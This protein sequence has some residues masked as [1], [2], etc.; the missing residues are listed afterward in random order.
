MKLFRVIRKRTEIAGYKSIIRE[1][2][3]KDRSYQV[4][5]FV[6]YLL[7]KRKVRTYYM[8]LTFYRSVGVFDSFG[9]APTTIEEYGRLFGHKWVYAEHIEPK[10]LKRCVYGFIEDF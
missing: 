8:V 5:V 3:V 1:G 10:S 9:L 2:Y 6:T 7:F 4:D